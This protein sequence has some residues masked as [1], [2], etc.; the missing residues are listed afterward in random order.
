[1]ASSAHPRRY[2]D[3]TVTWR[4]ATREGVV[5][6]GGVAQLRGVALARKR[7]TRAGAT[8]A[9]GKP[10][11][12]AAAG[13]VMLKARVLILCVGLWVFGLRKLGLG[14]RF[15]FGFGYRFGFS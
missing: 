14:F 4:G 1:M 2:R 15:R 10:G 8:R 13:A 11:S 7:Y 3:R 9:R 6:G 5:P 12:V